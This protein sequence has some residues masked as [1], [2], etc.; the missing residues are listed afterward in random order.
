[1]I[2]TNDEIVKAHG[3]EISAGSGGKAATKKYEKTTLI[4]I[5]SFSD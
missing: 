1:V 5:L 2:Q 3:R 4:I